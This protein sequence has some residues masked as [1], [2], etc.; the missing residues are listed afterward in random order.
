MV[1]SVRVNLTKQQLTRGGCFF[2]FASPENSCAS[3]LCL[4]VDT[5]TGTEGEPG[6]GEERGG[7]DTTRGVRAFQKCFS[8]IRGQGELGKV[9]HIARQLREENA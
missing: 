2:L 4:S 5:E 3:T 9:L 8:S 7:G 1:Y 6:G